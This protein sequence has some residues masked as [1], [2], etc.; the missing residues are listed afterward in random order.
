MTAIR[1][2]PFFSTDESLLLPNQTS[3]FFMKKIFTLAA[4][5]ALPLI[6]AA[7]PASPEVMQHVN[8]D[9]SVVEFR[10]FGD[11]FFNYTTDVNRDVILTR[12]AEGYLVPLVRDGRVFHA[13][14]A[15]I[16]TLEAEAAAKLTIKSSK[17]NR[18]ADIDFNGRTLYP[19][20]GEAPALVILLEYADTEFVSADPKLQYTR[21]CNEEGYSDYDG[22]GSVKDYFKACSNGKFAPNFEVYG[23]VKLKEKSSYYAG[24]GTNLPQANHNARFGEAIKEAIEALDDE[25]DFSRYDMD[26]DGTIDNIFFLYAGYGQADTGNR[27]LIWPHEWDYL[28][29]TDGISN[30]GSMLKLPRLTPDNVEVRSY[31][32]SNELNGSQRIPVSKRP[33]L[34]GIGAFCHEY[35]HVLGIPDL[36]NTSTINTKSPGYYDVMDQGSYNLN[37]TCPPLFSAYEQWVCRW[38]EFDEA[39]NDTDVTLH[40]MSSEERNALRYQGKRSIPPFTADADFHVFEYRAQEGWDAGLPDE[41]MFIWRINFNKNVWTSNIVNSNGTPHV[42]MINV[43]GTAAFAWPGAEGEFPYIAPSQNALVSATSGKTLDITLSDITWDK[44]ADVITFGYN[45]VSVLTDAPVLNAHPTVET[46]ARRVHLS[47]TP[48]EGATDYILSLQRT[49][50]SGVSLSVEDYDNKRTGNVTSLV[51]E[52]ISEREWTQLFTAS[53]RAFNGIPS[54]AVSNIINFRP[55]ELAEDTGVDEIAGEIPMIFG[56]AGCNYAPDNAEVYTLGGIR[57]GK[58]NLPAGVYIV[59]TPSAVAKVVVR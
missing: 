5:L 33:Y 24:T 2:T 52:N 3:L 45:T 39:A 46:D 36:Y 42:E 30:L 48:V 25:V 23:P 20:I 18:M 31:A 37:S 19:S 29:Y 11:S 40:P 43:P 14:D 15:D 8:P 57:T 34:D 58:E 47:W 53:I 12:N 49:N 50:N 10:T 17:Q 54:T 28:V 27:D 16:K 13:V 55:S 38:I 4:A 6:A 9:G 41:G 22:R 35:G 56:G 32:C 44:E 7:R 21:F 59:K 51:I 26:K 1:S